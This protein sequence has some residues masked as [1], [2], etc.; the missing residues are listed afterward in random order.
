[1]RENPQKATARAVRV[2]GTDERIGKSVVTHYTGAPESASQYKYKHGCPLTRIP[3]PIVATTMKPI[4]SPGDASARKRVKRPMPMMVTAHANQLAGRYLFV[5]FTTAPA[6]IPTV[7]LVKVN[8]K[9]LTLE[10][11]G[12]E[13]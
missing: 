7:G 9:N 1:M 2:I 5:R 3:V 12:L 10:R 8:A 4:H 6:T 13:P 11:M